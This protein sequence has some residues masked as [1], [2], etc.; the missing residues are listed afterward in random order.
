MV[1]LFAFATIAWWNARQPQ[2]PAAPAW[3]FARTP[4]AFRLIDPD[5]DKAPEA[6]LARATERPARQFDTFA[7]WVLD[8]ESGVHWVS[9]AKYEVLDSIMQSARRRI[10]YDPAIRNPRDERR[11]AMHILRTIDQTLTEHNVVYPPG[12]YDTTE[13]RLGLSPQRFDRGMLDRVLRVALNARRRQHA[14]ANANE[15]FYVLDCDTC[16][17]VYLGIAEAC[18]FGNRLHLVDLPDHMFVR[19]VFSDGSHVNWDTN[20][21]SVVDDRE[22]AADYELSRKLRRGRVYLSS[23]TRAEAMGHVYFLR[24]GTYE[25]QG[26]IRKAIADMKRVRELVPQSTQ[27]KSDLAWLYATSGDASAAELREALELASVAADMEPRCGDF[28]DTLAMV[29]AASG[30]FNKAVHCA[31]KA[32]QFALNGEDRAEFRARR[33]DFARGRLPAVGE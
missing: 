24:A 15:P 7:H 16:S 6:R 32:V 8:V 22:Y 21:A 31:D 30:D 11:Q 10:A 26:E 25:N 1:V 14:K 27:A 17:F 3:A 33:R 28:W 4:Q 13:L 29:H 23:L 12:D 5:E 2:Y 20:D 19:W 18:G 9:P